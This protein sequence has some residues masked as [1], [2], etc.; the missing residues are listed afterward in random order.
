[1]NGTGKTLEWEWGF[2]AGKCISR[3]DL[4]NFDGISNFELVNIS[5]ERSAF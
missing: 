1:M 5:R 3:L 2:G 4:K